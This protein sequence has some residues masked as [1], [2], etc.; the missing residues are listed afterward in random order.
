MGPNLPIIQ[1][2]CNDGIRNAMGDGC[3]NG[4]NERE[5]PCQNADVQP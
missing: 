2:L 3:M 1:A 4:M 5:R